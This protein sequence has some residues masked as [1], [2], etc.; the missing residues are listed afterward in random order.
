MSIG[1][2]NLISKEVILII[3]YKELIEML[4]KCI[5]DNKEMIIDATGVFLEG[6]NE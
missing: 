6:L 4:Y 1:K 5:Y 2:W 3:T